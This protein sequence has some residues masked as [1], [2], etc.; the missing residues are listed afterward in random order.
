MKKIIIPAVVVSLLLTSCATILNRSHQ[1]VNFYGDEP[2]SKMV[3]NDSVYELP[4]RLGVE[5]SHKNLEVNY[6]TNETS[7]NSIRRKLDFKYLPGNIFFGPA[8]GVAFLTEGRTPKKYRYPSDILLTHQKFEDPDDLIDYRK[9]YLHKH[10]KEIE[11]NRLFVDEKEQ[12][13]FEKHANKSKGDRFHVIH[14]PS[15]S[16]FDVGTVDQRESFAGLFTLGYGFE[17]F[18]TD[19]MFW[20]AD[21]T[22]RTNWF[23]LILSATDTFKDSFVQSSIAFHN[24]HLIGKRWEAGYGI[25]ASYNRLNYEAIYY[26]Y[27]NGIFMSTTYARIKDYYMSVGVSGR[28]AY[29]FGKGFYGGISYAPDFMKFA[30]YGNRSEYNATYGLDL[31]FKF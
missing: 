20:S 26:N 4:V 25:K 29:H 2:N 13:V 21:F 31:R 6:L 1:K 7:E 8:S 19:K 17:K 5:R 18:Y 22:V 16:A 14:F 27:N 28:V 23:D 30:D 11:N 9:D 10:R 24:N 15:F 3:Y 12:Y